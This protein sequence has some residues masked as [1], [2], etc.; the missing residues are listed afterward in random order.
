M[1]A[2]RDLVERIKAVGQEIIDR[3]E[4]MASGELM[5]NLDIH[6]SMG[7]AEDRIDYIEWTTSVVNKNSFKKYITEKEN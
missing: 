5:T 3:A 1:N 2:K 6:A 7:V 4:E